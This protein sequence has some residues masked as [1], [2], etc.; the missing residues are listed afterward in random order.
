MTLSLVL[1]GGVTGPGVL[2]QQD[3]NIWARGGQN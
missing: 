2:K 1:R 3:H